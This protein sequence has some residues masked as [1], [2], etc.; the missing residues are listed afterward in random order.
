MK[1]M[2]GVRILMQYTMPVNDWIQINLIYHLKSSDADAPPDFGFLL[3]SA[4]DDVVKLGCRLIE[5]FQ[6]KTN[7]TKLQNMIGSYNNPDLEAQIRQ[8][9]LKL[10]SF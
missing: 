4:N 6:Q 7:V 5:V 1:G 2:E 10:E 9:I 8:T 3:S